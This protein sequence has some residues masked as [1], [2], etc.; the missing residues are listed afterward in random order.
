VIRQRKGRQHE[1][2]ERE[3]LRGGRRRQ[4][5]SGWTGKR[6]RTSVALIS[7]R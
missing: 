3:F 6:T 2:L 7:H 1:E 5:G 4:D